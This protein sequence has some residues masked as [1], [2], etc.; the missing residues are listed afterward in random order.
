MTDQDYECIRAGINELL[1][2]E[3]GLP[4]GEY[5]PFGP[6]GSSPY[7]DTPFSWARLLE[8]FAHLDFTEDEA[9]AHWQ[10][11][12]RNGQELSRKLG[13]QV[14]I[15]LAIVDYFTNIN[16]LM[17]SPMLIEVHV[18]RQTELLAMVDG[19][20]GLFNRRYM[21][22]VLRKEF[23][24]GERYGKEFT[25][26]LIDIDNFKTINDTRGHQF[27]DLV[28]KEI[29]SLLRDSVRSEDMVCRYGGEEFMII[30]PE[31]DAVGGRIF[32]ERIHAETR[33]RKF[34]VDNGI[35]F[36]GGIAS[37]PLCARNVENLVKSAD[38]ALYR[39][40][41]GGKD[42]L[43]SADAERRK[44][45]R[46]SQ[47]WNLEIFA[48]EGSVP[49]K[50]IITQNVSLG[51]VQFECPMQFRIDAPLH[52]KLTTTDPEQ[53]SV[54]VDG[55]ISWVKRHRDSYIYGVRFDVLPKMLENS[56]PGMTGGRDEA[57][58]E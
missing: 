11:I 28:L 10:G 17:T 23:T 58:G 57:I 1:H 4:P 36:S 30:L 42:H 6:A 18:F 24:R 31:T 47:S 53:E 9:L 32:G 26:C 37:Y 12:I 46:Y 8:N 39:A 20:T 25:I 43:E 56:L 44:F 33:K 38:K 15:H 14:G 54:E 29:A 41:F 16:P 7:R 45:G 19:L 40:K 48:L 49:S 52:L 3:I 2:Q 51:G 22:I 5:P 13:R 21:D 27:G 34:F 35:T 50:G 55:T